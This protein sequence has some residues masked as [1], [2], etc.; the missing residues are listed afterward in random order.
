[1]MA[2]FFIFVP[3]IANICHRHTLYYYNPH[4]SI[5][6]KSNLLTIAAALVALSLATSCNT[7]KKSTQQVA[8]VKTETLSQTEGAISHV[9]YGEWTAYDVNGMAVTGDD[10]PYVIFDKSGSNPYLVQ[11][12]ANN[13]CNTLNGT[14]AITPGG[15][16]KP[17]SDF[18]STMRLCPDAKYEMG[19][20]MA[21]NY[22]TGYKIEQVGSE[23]LMYL[24]DA[25][26]KNLMVLRKADAGYMNGAWRVTR[27]NDKNIAESQNI[28]MVI[29]MADLKVHGNAGCNVL[30]GSLFIDQA[31]QNSLQFRDLRTTRMTCP[32]IATEQALLVALEQVETVVPGRD[33]KTA[34]LK[35]ASGQVLITLQRITLK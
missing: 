29:D 10:R 1:M 2:D 9:I 8:N 23:Y 3:T 34:L 25:Q 32:D 6:M 17:T 7:T 21:L 11:C 28:E 13:G 31:K 12:Y 30:N 35:D 5:F 20:N 33:D 4:S 14:Y 27:I 15:S 19:F 18:A 26:G 16:M 22:V 24:T